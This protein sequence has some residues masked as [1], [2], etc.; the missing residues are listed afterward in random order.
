MNG[1]VPLSVLLNDTILQ[2]QIR[3]QVQTIVARAAAQNDWLGPLDARSQA[4]PRG[5]WCIWSTYRGM[6]ALMQYAEVASDSDRE[7]IGRLL[8]RWAVILADFLES[9][10]VLPADFDSVRWEEAAASLQTLLDSPLAVAAS[11]VE[12]AAARRAMELLSVQG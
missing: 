2:T 8:F 12:R 5:C 4:I 10:P 7:S 11:A 9:K 6:T 3:S 1:A